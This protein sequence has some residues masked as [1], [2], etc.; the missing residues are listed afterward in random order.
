MVGLWSLLLDAL[1]H[2]LGDNG[3]DGK[4]ITNLSVI[5]QIS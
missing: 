1:A 2:E 3:F 4:P 5:A